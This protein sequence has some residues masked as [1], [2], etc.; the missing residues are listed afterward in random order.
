MRLGCL[1]FVLALLTACA[2]VPVPPQTEHAAA[3]HLTH[4]HVV[5]SG[6]TLESI[7]LLYDLNYQDLARW[8]SIDPP[9]TIYP[10]QDILLKNIQRISRDWLW[11]GSG[12]LLCAFGQNPC[13]RGI[14]IQGIPDQPVLASSAGQV[15]YSG[16]SIP[17]YGG[18]VVLK[19]DQTYLSAY[20]YN[21][22]L[23]VREGD[24]V[25]R[26]Q[27]LATM[28][29]G[30]NGKIILYFEIRM[31]GRSIDPLRLLSEKIE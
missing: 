17:G 20:G 19:H 3:E 29:A 1:V 6:E 9:Y 24:E 21:K 28:G 22:D 8:N 11:P 27:K 2:S 12:K 18:L 15:V 23:L 31:H 10:D 7:A 16:Y 5:Q 13:R 4:T 30:R 26:G 25:I 14:Y